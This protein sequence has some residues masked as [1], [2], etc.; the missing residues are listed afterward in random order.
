MMLLRPL[1]NHFVFH[2]KPYVI[3]CRLVWQTT[4]TLP[5]NTDI[6]RQTQLK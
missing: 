5:Y 6:F 2:F 4:F 1:F 3:T